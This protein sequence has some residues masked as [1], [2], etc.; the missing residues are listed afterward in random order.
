MIPRQIAK[1][2][3]D[4]DFL[5][6]ES[7]KPFQLSALRIHFV[8]DDT[9]VADLTISLDAVDGEEYDADLFVVAGV[10]VGNDVNLIFSAR[11]L[12]QPS[13]QRFWA[14]DRI[15]I[16]WANPA[17]GTISW[18]LRLESGDF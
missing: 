9:T 10:G 12:E 13:G 16:Q 18:G 4:I 17:S 5:S 11:E 3:S 14:G 15:R 6:G 2:N 8:G 7:D 1:G